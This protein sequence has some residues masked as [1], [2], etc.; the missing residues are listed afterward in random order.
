MREIGFI[1]LGKLGLE[2]AEAMVNSKNRVHGFD[3][4][5]RESDK[6][7]IH[8]DIKDVIVDKEFIFIAVQTPHNVQYDGS[9]PSSH[10]PVKDF[11]YETVIDVLNS[12][13]EY[14][15]EGQTIVL[16]ST[17][18]PGTCREQFIPIIKKGVNFIYNPYLI[19]MGTTTWDMLN[20]EMVI[21]GSND[22]DKKIVDNLI[23]FYESIMEKQDT[24]YEIGTL[25]EA[26]CIKVFYN[27]F[28]SAKIG[29]TNMIQ[30]VAEKSNN[31][32]C[33]IVANAL[34]KSTQRI[35]GEM[36]MKPGMGDGGPCHPRDN[37]ALSFLS[38]KL[39]LGYDL[40]GAIMESREVQAE[41]MAKKLVSYGMP[42]TILGKSYKPN[43]SYVDGS[44]SLLVSHYATK[45]SRYGVGFDENWTTKPC[46]YLLAHQNKYHDFHFNQGS[47]V[48]DPW[49][50]F[51]RNDSIHN[52]TLREVVYYGSYDN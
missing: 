31:I 15:V 10:L 3:L 25:D 12:V 40:F 14:V 41:N 4:Y 49:R 43:V 44:Y 26:E 24:R 11:D 51:T 22:I 18:L 17:V 2:C 35:M 7:I 9:E 52:E 32:N 45:M 13:N 23:S 21:I 34:A 20:P 19:A 48:V 36:Y 37:I 1:G 8:Q 5:A 38:K 39:D 28:I 27:T 42:I 50:E 16:I 30:D 29:L 47:V 6:I 33:D 46:V